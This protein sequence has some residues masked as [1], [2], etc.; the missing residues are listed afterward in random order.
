MPA[1]LVHAVFNTVFINSDIYIYT[2]VIVM[3]L[4]TPHLETSFVVHG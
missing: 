3:C 2:Y 4:P 1:I